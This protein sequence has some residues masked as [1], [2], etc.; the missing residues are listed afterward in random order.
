MSDSKEDLLIED[1]IAEVTSRQPQTKNP[2]A[3]VHLGIGESDLLSIIYDKFSKKITGSELNEIFQEVRKEIVSRKTPNTLQ[4]LHTI[5]RNCTKCSL[6]VAPELPK[7]NT[8]DPSV[9]VVAENPAIQQDAVSLLVDAAKK[10]S[11]AS[12]DLCLTY[13]NRCPVP[14]KFS[15]QEVLNCSPYLHNEINLLNPK[16]ILTLGATSASVIFGNEV[17]LKNYRGKIN[18]LGYW[19]VLSTYSPAY[20][21]SAGDSYKSMLYDDFMYAYS[22]VN[23]SK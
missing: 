14:K 3:K 11:F 2:F 9:V 15:S 1:L 18:W 7:W 13:V 19:P 5:T 12:E 17:K 21:L 4:E 22:F 16:L 23:E 8:K 20:A 6:N 10:A